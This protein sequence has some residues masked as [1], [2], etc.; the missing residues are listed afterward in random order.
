MPVTIAA[1]FAV[2][3][4]R[5]LRMLRIRRGWLQADAGVKARLSPATIGRHENGI[6]GSLGSL[7]RHAAVFGLRVDLRLT[8]R[9]GQLARLADEEHAAIV[10][11]IAA[12]FNANGFLTETEASF[13]EWGE[14]GRVDLLAYDPRSGTLVIVE[15]KTELLDLQDLFGALNV[16]ERLAAIIAERRGWTVRRRHTLLAVAS[17]FANREIVRTHP[18]LFGRFA[19]RRLSRAAFEG[20]SKGILHWVAPATA[21]R[22]SWRAGRQRVRRSPGR[23]DGQPI[24]TG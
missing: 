10:E 6:V 18:S 8:G 2:A 3:I 23:P 12:W 24:L 14:R 1:M 19:T 17:T 4:G 13:N 22:T 11:A 20:H 21:R 16:K 5:L 15:I 7:E 9:G